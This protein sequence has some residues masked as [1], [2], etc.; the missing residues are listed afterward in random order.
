MLNCD[1]I[2][3]R[4]PLRHPRCPSSSDDVR[5]KSWI[6]SEILYA[7]NTLS[8]LATLGTQ[9]EVMAYFSYWCKQFYVLEADFTLG[10]FLADPSQILHAPVTRVVRYIPA[11]VSYL[12]HSPKTSSGKRRILVK[13]LEGRMRNY[14]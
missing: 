8:S 2:K 7:A 3:L 9:C 14:N 12:R 4:K 11:L 13:L 1:W 5:N 10:R 6:S